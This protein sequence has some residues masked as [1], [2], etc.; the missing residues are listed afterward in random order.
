MSGTDAET[1]ESLVHMFKRMFSH[2]LGG[3][4]KPALADIR[5]IF[6]DVFFQFLQIGVIITGINYLT[7]F[8]VA[9]RV[10]ELDKI[11][12][13]PLWAM[14]AIITFATL[15]FANFWTDRLKMGLKMSEATRKRSE[16]FTRILKNQEKIMNKLGIKEEFE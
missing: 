9:I 6:A 16:P 12:P 1:E 10:Y 3:R 4:A 5:D 11:I 8:S 7:N 15:I 14:L 13:I 2:I